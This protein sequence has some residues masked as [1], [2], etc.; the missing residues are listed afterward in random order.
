MPVGQDAEGVGDRLAGDRADLGSHRLGP[1]VCGPVRVLR[2]GPQDLAETWHVGMRQ[3]H[4][5]AL[6]LLASLAAHAGEQ[7]VESHQFEEKTAIAEQV[8][9]SSITVAFRLSVLCDARERLERLDRNPQHLGFLIGRKDIREQTRLGSL[10]AQERP[11]VLEHSAFLAILEQL[12]R[13]LQ[14]LPDLQLAQILADDLRPRPAAAEGSHR[15]VRQLTALAEKQLSTLFEVHH[16]E[17]KVAFVHGRAPTEPMKRG[18]R[19]VGGRDAEHAHGQG[20]DTLVGG[21]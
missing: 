3:A 7:S 21:P 6:G 2:H 19:R 11:E 18:R 13:V 10:R 5:P 12:L 15:L 8:V 20:V 1:V 14:D 9:E 16:A 17:I 4:R